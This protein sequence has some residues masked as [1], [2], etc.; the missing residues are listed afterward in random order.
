M[1]ALQDDSNIMCQWSKEMMVIQKPTQYPLKTTV[2]VLGWGWG[3]V[4]H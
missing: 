3:G 2:M 4:W 1:A